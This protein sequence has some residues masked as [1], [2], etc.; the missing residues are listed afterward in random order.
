MLQALQLYTKEN[1]CEFFKQQIHYLGRVITKD[2]LMMDP[3]KVEAIVKWPPPMNIVKLQVFLGLANFY[4]K[5]IQD[6]AKLMVPMMDQLCNKGKTF[7]WN[8][9]Q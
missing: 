4:Q 5:Y 8:E 7:Q 1:K 6:Y 2:D 9:A 3:T